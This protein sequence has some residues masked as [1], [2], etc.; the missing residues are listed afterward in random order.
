[1]KN[2]KLIYHIEINSYKPIWVKPILISLDI[3]LTSS[4][5]CTSK[6]TNPSSDAL[7]TTASS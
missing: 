5:P 2:D 3:D 7:C 1:M 6:F 4:D